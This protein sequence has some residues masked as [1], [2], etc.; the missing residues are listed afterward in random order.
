M[1]ASGRI[2]VWAL[3][4]NLFYALTANSKSL[5]T[6]TNIHL[7][8][9]ILSHTCSFISSSLF[10]FISRTQPPLL[11]Y[12]IVIPKLTAAI[13][14]L[15]V[16]GFIFFSQSHETLGKTLTSH[17]LRTNFLKPLSVQYYLCQSNNTETN[18]RHANSLIS[19]KRGEGR[20]VI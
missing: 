8:V 4:I 7:F 14:L 2:A 1:P 16:L 17:M 19:S 18:K 6:H 12:S 11:F 5:P 15:H 3:A 20:T 13:F 10:A 9:N